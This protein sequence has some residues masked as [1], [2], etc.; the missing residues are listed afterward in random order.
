MTHSRAMNTA[1]VV[2]L[3]C[4]AVMTAD[5]APHAVEPLNPDVDSVVPEMAQLQELAPGDVDVLGNLIKL[6]AYSLSAWDDARIIVS[7]H[8]GKYSAILDFVQAYGEA[9]GGVKRGGRSAE[10]QGGNIVTE[11]GLVMASLMTKYSRGVNAYVLKSLDHAVRHDPNGAVHLNTK[12][13]V[14][15]NGGKDGHKIG[16]AAFLRTKALGLE[17]SPQ[18]VT[19]ISA[20]YADYLHFKALV[21]AAATD[22]DA[23]AATMFLQSKSHGHYQ[24]FLQRE[25][26]KVQRRM[27]HDYDV[28]AKAA[29]GSAREAFT[30]AYNDDRKAFFEHI[31]VMTPAA[32]EAAD[33]AVSKMDWVPPTMEEMIAIADKQKKEFMEQY[34]AKVPDT[35]KLLKKLME[36]VGGVKLFISTSGVTNAQ[37]T[38]KPK[39]EFIGKTGHL[40]A[41]IRAVPG[42]LNTFVQHFPAQEP[43]GDIQK[44]VLTGTGADES[45]S[46]NSVKVRVGGKDAPVVTFK[47]TNTKAEAFWLKSGETIEL[48]VD[49]HKAEKDE[50]TKKGC[51]AFR[52]TAE[53]DA[54]GVRTPEEDMGCTD[55]VDSMHS[56]FCKCDSGDVAKV[57]CGHDTFTCDEMCSE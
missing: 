33:K 51:L 32:A 48:V 28:V 10:F 18:I 53:C 30:K 39:V 15:G 2:M 11:Y 31:Q 35:G 16:A 5:A 3:V 22:A 55:D 57:D 52:A 47:P 41:E 14:I 25:I 46:C 13:K 19:E 12:M 29:F 4:A 38:M 36:H 9:G 49:S 23:L 40:E 1:V 44:V 6:K 54:N 17:D 37:S 43:I 56:G 8:S 26:A 20:K 50:Y 34:K 42:Q 21:S 7:Q 24:S 45:W 27:R